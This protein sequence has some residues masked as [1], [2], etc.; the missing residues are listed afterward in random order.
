M[1]PVLRHLAEFGRRPPSWI[2]QK[3]DFIVIVLKSE[4]NDLFT[5]RLTTRTLSAFPG[6]PL[7]SVINSAAKIFFIRVSPP[8][9]CHPGRLYD[10]QAAKCKFQYFLSFYRKEYCTILNHYCTTN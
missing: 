1:G 2:S 10:S 5:H 8:A 3:V 7:S 4:S 6:D 9:W